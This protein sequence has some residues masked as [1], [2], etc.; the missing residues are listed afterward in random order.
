MLKHFDITPSIDTITFRRND[1]GIATE[2]ALDGICVVRTSLPAGSIGSEGA[3]EAYR[4]LSGVERAFRCAKSDLSVRPIHVRTEEHDR[5]HVFLCML[6]YYV[7]WH[8]RRRLAP[9]LFEDDDREDAR[10]QR[11]SPVAKAGVSPGAKRKA[12]TKRTRNGLPVHS[13]ATLLDD[14]STLTLN[15]VKA[16]GKNQDVT[17]EAPAKPTAVQK[18]ALELLGV[19]AAVAGRLGR[20]MYTKIQVQSG[21]GPAKPQRFQR[22]AEIRGRQTPVNFRLKNSCE[23][24]IH[25]A[26]QIHAG[27]SKGCRW[28]VLGH[29]RSTPRKHPPDQV[30]RY[31][32][33]E[34]NDKY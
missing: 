3:V 32:G 31:V 22:L 6:A 9:I 27:C 28:Q 13:F 21:G 4:A 24:L 2:A 11:P 5:G 7:E 29:R 16:A 17:F 23:R 12:S 1:A 19:D 20:S 33:I 25:A 26:A 15:T 34:A 18:A 14:L 30:S 10:A 8:M